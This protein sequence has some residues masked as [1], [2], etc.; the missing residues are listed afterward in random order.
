MSINLK[1]TQHTERFTDEELFQQFCSHHSNEAFE[2][3]VHRYERPLFAYLRRMMHS[4]Q[5]AEDVFQSTFL[6]VFLKRDS[7]DLTRRFQPWLYS[8]ATRQAIDTM[9]KE[10][11]HHHTVSKRVSGKPADDACLDNLPG[12][13]RTPSELAGEQE[14]WSNVRKA[15]GR[16]SMVQ[17]KAVE[18]VY[19]KGLA[20]REAAGVLGVPVGTVKSRVHA[21]ILALGGSCV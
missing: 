21:A 18:L 6:R 14:E 11:R 2:S 4:Q 19:G 3:L 9:R 1:T 5:L 17:R 15:V 10:K 20:Y 13:D 12:G 8:V 16:L 7:F